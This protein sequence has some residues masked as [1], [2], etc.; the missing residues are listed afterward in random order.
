M[1]LHHAALA[2]LT[3]VSCTALAEQEIDRRAPAGAQG[4]VEVDNVSGTVSVS[5]WDRNEVHVSGTLG[6]GV[7]R[8]DF[9]SSGNRTVIKV[10][11]KNRGRHHDDT[12]LS[13]RVPRGS[14]LNVNTVSAELSVVGVTGEQR[15]QTVSGDISTSIS[16][17]D[18]EISTVSG[19][20]SLRGDGSPTNLSVTTVSGD[21]RLMK[22]GGDVRANSV[23]GS[24]EVSMN[25]IKRARAQ[26]TSGDL[27][28]SGKLAADARVDA[29]S[30]SG[31]LNL[32]L[33]GTPNAYFDIESFSGEIENCFGPKPERT[34]KYGPGTELH[35]KS[36]NG[37]GRVRLQTLSG[38]ISVCSN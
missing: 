4:E 35:F 38:S 28:L 34:D 22:V 2:A 16:K 37:S 13:I 18:A 31:E 1:K 26:T 23:S 15:L 12:E 33:L 17:A 19:S 36:G 32:D 21:A 29:E 14:L 3:L 30:I 5:G 24:V 27:A 8:L 11:M 10:V 9:E 6:D 7:E 25:E 20:V